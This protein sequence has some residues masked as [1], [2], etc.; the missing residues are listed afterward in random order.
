MTDIDKAKLLAHLT[1]KAQHRNILIKA[2][3]GGLITA[4]NRGDFDRKES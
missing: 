3:F 1:V 4:I 2:V